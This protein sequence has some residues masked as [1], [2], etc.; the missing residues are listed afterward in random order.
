MTDTGQSI[1]VGDIIKLDEREMLFRCLTITS[2][3]DTI[4]VLGEEIAPKGPH[5][6]ARYE[7]ERWSKVDD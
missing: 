5:K 3:G 1:K 2:S 4:Y 6:F 7:L